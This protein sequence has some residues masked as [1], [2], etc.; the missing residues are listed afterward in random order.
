MYKQW[1]YGE[2]GRTAKHAVRKPAGDAEAGPMFASTISRAAGASPSSKLCQ[3][4][5]SPAAGPGA[6]QLVGKVGSGVA[7]GGLAATI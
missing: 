3:K 1:S 6:Y 2:L 7:A 4:L 5:S